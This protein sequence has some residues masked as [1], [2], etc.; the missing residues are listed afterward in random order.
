MKQLAFVIELDRCIG[1]KGCQVSCKMTNGTHLGSD[2]IKVRQMGPY[3]IH[4]R[5]EMYFLPTMCQQCEDPACIKGCPSNAIYKSKEDG[6]VR[7][8]QKKC[9]GCKSCNEQCPYQAN[10]YSEMTHTMDKCT[11]CSEKRAEGGGP[12]CVKNCTG[13]ALHFGDINDPESEVYKL[14]AEA[15][16]EHVYHLPD[17]GNHPSAR[18]ILKTATWQDVLPPAL[19]KV[20]FTRKGGK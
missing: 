18:Y 8:D 12:A 4:P 16:E 11:L 2:R 10:T 7:I 20:S 5:L 17:S 13:K 9:I 6:V 1:C 3:G 19:D 15:G 14:L